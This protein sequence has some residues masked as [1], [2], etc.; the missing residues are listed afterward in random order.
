[1]ALARRGL[2][3]FPLRPRDKVPLTSDGFKSATTDSGLIEH[4]WHDVPAA[5]IGIATGERSGIFVLDVD[6]A[7]R[8]K[9][10]ATVPGEGVFQSARL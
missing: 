8:P 2:W 1:L 3:V 4:W 10:L 9:L 6:G 5:N 7:D